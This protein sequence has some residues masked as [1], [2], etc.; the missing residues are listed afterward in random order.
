M[1]ALNAFY[2]HHV[3][4]VRCTDAVFAHILISGAVVK[5]FCCVIAWKAQN[6][7]ARWCPVAF[8][9]LASAA[10]RQIFTASRGN[11]GRR[12]CSI[13]FELFGVGNL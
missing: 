12:K 13:L 7:Y 9:R 11:S 1:K 5:S 3:E 8:E 10:S 4:V 2:Q 6:G